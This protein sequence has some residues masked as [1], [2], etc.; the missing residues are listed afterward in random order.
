MSTLKELRNVR[1]EKLRRLRAAGVD[2]YPAATN[3][4]HTIGT[5][6][7][8]F[9]KIESSGERI[10]IAG[11]IRS[12]REH[13]EICFADLE[14]GTGKLQLLL[15]SDTLKSPTVKQFVELYDIGD[16]AE[17]AGTAI[18]TKSGE[19]T[20]QAIEIRLLAKTLR[21]LPEKWH[22]LQ[23]VEA[24]LRRRYVDLLMNP[25]ERA[26]FVKKSRFWQEIR[27]VLITEGFLEVETPVLEEVPGGADAE[28]FKTHLN[29][30]DI[31]LYLRIS[32]EL[33]LKRLLVGGY[34]KVFEIGRI[35]RNEG[36]DREH[37]QDYTQMEV[38]WAY[39]DFRQMMALVERLY[40]TV[41]EKILASLQHGH[42]NETIDWSGAWPEID[43]CETFEKH[44]SLDL[45]N[46]SAETLSEYA[47]AEHIDT[48][49]HA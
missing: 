33:H 31:D 43:Y 20:I 12:V 44:T 13:G 42:Q 1:V 4:T 36:M 30:L 26:F 35:F 22:G 41:I 7:E 2:P 25:D 49:K 17:A 8:H 39:A 23:N 34:E 5:V 3:R 15:K 24:R 16:F 37:L 45:R 27:N 11:R 29:A 6:R 18:T 21:P 9:A 14:D 38:Y 40:K 19:L 47:R 48:A 28:P 46:A 32:P 10:T